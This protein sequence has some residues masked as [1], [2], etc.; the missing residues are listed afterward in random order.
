MINIKDIKQQAKKA[1]KFDIGRNANVE[2][3]SFITKF[4][5]AFAIFTIYFIC[6]AKLGSPMAS[7]IAFICFVVA[8][9][10][11]YIFIVAPMNFGREYYFVKVSVKVQ[12]ETDELFYFFRHKKAVLLP[13]I[14]IAISVVFYTVLFIAG[15]ICYFKIYSIFSSNY[16][17]FLNVIV[18]AAVIVFYAAVIIS[19]RIKYSF[20][21]SVYEKYTG[22]ESAILLSKS[23]KFSKG[24][25]FDLFLFY[26]SFAGWYLL[27]ILSLGIGFVWIM[28][29][30]RIATRIYLNKCID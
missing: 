18:V 25:I 1:Y 30:I 9:I 28:P 27:G 2:F 17:S 19:T 12:P 26:L 16:F 15:T 5:V 13:Y 29:Y 7:P 10:L 23:F 21:P 8:Y 11:H 14:R 6:L 3:V 22:K 20:Y 4:S 24:K